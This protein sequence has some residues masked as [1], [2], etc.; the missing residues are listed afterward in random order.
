M[1]DPVVE[2]Q[3]GETAIV[4]FGLLLVRR[5]VERTLGADYAGPFVRCRLDGWRRT[6]GATMPNQ[7][8]FYETEEGKVY[9][10]QIAYLDVEPAPEGRVNCTVI[11]VDEEQ[12]AAMN[13]REWIYEAEVVT[14]ALRGV[15]VVGGDAL[16]YRASPGH[17]RDL[18]AGLPDVAIRQTY[19]DGLNS[20]LQGLDADQRSRFVAT[21]EV[22]P[23]HLVVDDSL[24]P[25]RPNPWEAAGAAFDPSKQVD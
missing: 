7:A 9:P 22:A 14:D 11:V 8:F 17:R 10:R 2:V 6:W 3:P 16:V 13:A 5:T 19:L 20:M 12:L 21:T 24:D 18:E 15:Q 23:P 4:G 1:A 25:N